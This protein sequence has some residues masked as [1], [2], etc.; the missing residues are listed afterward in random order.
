MNGRGIAVGRSSY[1]VPYWKGISLRKVLRKFKNLGGGGGG[2]I[3][4]AGLEKG[5]EEE[6]STQKKKNLCG[7]LGTDFHTKRGGGGRGGQAQ[8]AHASPRTDV[9][10]RRSRRPLQAKFYGDVWR[11]NA[12]S[13]KR[14]MGGVG[15]G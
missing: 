1:V 14:G 9:E 2:G 4:C 5:E 11:F 12:T 15:Y 10:P 7:P 3:V 6:R 13:T 8:F